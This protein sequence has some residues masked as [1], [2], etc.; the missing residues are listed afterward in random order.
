MNPAE[1]P[2]RALREKF[3]AGRDGFRVLANAD[4]ALHDPPADHTDTPGR[5][6]A[7]L[8]GLAALP[9]ATPLSL[10]EP[11]PASWGAL[12][13][14]HDS[15]YLLALES[16]IHSGRPDFMH[17]DCPL[18]HGSGEAILAAAGLALALGETLAEGADG[19][20]LTRPPGHHAGPARAEGF[21]FLNHAAL[22]A[23]R[24]RSK[25][26]EARVA[27]VDLDLHHGNGTQA[28]L[29]N[30][31]GTL[32]FSLHGD[33]AELLYPNGGFISENRDAPAVVRARPLPAGCDGTVWLAA[34]DEGLAQVA[35]FRPD[36]ILVSLGLDAHEADPFGFFR[37]TDEDFVA[38]IDRIRDLA[39]SRPGGP[40][41]IGL[42]LEGGYSEPVLERLV[43]R[44]VARLAG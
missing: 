27:V 30:I 3:P 1:P 7:C 35:G 2:L 12:R 19:L 6:V 43:P 25:H 31:P 15:G 37:L 28:C 18:G 44:L 17:R 13:A 9:A 42:L 34:L 22:A 40:A 20:A 41:R 21:C 36:A 33:P 10:R 4:C 29:E 38:A 5:L 11:P 23:Q 39:R 26:P 8:R 24:L 32:F 16:S 14:V